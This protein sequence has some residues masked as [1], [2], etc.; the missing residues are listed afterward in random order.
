ML[1][2]VKNSKPCTMKK[3]VYLQQVIGVQDKFMWINKKNKRLVYICRYN[4]G[5]PNKVIIDLLLNSNVF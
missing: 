2:L 1:Y 5:F 3:K 4:A